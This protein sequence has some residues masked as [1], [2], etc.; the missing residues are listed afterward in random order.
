MTVRPR[1]VGSFFISR[2]SERAKLPAVASRR[3]TSSRVRSPI[4]IKWRRG[5]RAGGR[6]SDIRRRS[7][8]GLLLGGGDQ[9]NTVDLVDLQELHLDALRACRRKV[10]A[11]VVGT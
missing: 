1:S 3:S 2:S 7:G 11:D 8:I 6:S 9:D 4:E 5:G 10:L